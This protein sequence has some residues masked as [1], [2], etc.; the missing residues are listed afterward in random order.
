MQYNTYDRLKVWVKGLSLFCLLIFLPSSALAQDETDYEADNTQNTDLQA[1]ENYRAIYDQAEQDYNIGRLEEARKALVE[2]LNDFPLSLKLSAYRILSL[3][4]LGVDDND[5]AER[6]VRMILDVN[7]YY[8]TTLSDPQRFI[9]MVE[10]TKDGRNATI[11]TASSQAETLAEVPVPTTLITREMIDNSCARNLQELLAAYV[12]SMIIV[13][14]NDDINI[15]MRGI[16]SN[17]QEKILIMLNGH[18]LNSYATNIAAPDFSM[19]LDKVQQIEVLRGPA[20]SLYGG[21]SLT[22]VVN[23]ITRKGGE[24]DGIELRAGGGSH[25]QV[26]AGMIFGKR[27]FDLDMLIWGNL[28]RATGESFFIPSE[29]TG[30]GI[31]EGDVTVGAIGPK[32]SYDFGLQMKYK[33]IQFLFTTLF[34]QVQSPYTMTYTFSPYVFD[35]YRTFS[36]I[37]PS[38]ATHT[39]HAKISYEHQ[40]NKVYLKA[41][42]TF[43]NSDL[44]HYQVITEPT[45]YAAVEVLP[46]PYE[47]ISALKGSDG[48]YRYLNAQEHTIGGK[49][50]GDWSYMDNDT[51]RGLLTFGAEYSYFQL[52][53]AHYLLGYNHT[54]TIAENDTIRTAC[55]GHE[56]NLNGYLQLKHHWRSFILNAG[57]RFDYKNRYDDT[58]IREFSPRLALI[59]IQPKWNIKLSYSKSFI[60]APYIYRKQNEILYN[61]MGQISYDQKLD[62]EALHSAQL[63]FGATQW[64]PGL[65]FEINGFYNHAR[66]LIYILL[67]NHGNI[68][69]IDNY[70]VEL[71]A[72][73]ERRRFT[74]NLSASWQTAARNDMFDVKLDYALNTPKLS[75]DL[76]LAW[77]A[78]KQLKLRTHID[79][80]GPQHTY[81]IDLREYA[82]LMGTINLYG[83]KWTEMHEYMESPDCDEAVVREMEEGLKL[84]EES[85][86]YHVENIPVFKDISARILFD[87][88]A[89]WRWRNLTLDVDVKNL[90]NHHYSISGMSTGLVPQRGR[91]FLATIG[92]KF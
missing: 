16:Y 73:Y 8:S 67:N 12:P 72:R 61:Y 18:R 52:D 7:P 42:A 24:V 57:L 81:Y 68:G 62:P 3:C 76:L 14:C 30:L 35:R 88:G 92:F 23:I 44:T 71:S 63:T 20:S 87:V 5:E 29:E 27:Y 39:N 48:I 22:A 6:Y 70:G 19:S 86:N 26:K 75:T 38:F 43:D 79:Y 21:V 50:Q 31:G 77:Q 69:A 45:V 55:K 1:G 56:S 37:G 36:G 25:G 33:D 9:D 83:E 34:S 59:Y 84:I 66:D 53:D 40:L 85:Y 17:G 60:D 74:A 2:N 82:A 41:S 54:Q 91:W 4:A 58:K 46:L 47:V 51:H 28:Y 89:T 90:F 78:T 10:N 49:L 64:L 80:K 65:N 15:A 13:D 11:T 32:P